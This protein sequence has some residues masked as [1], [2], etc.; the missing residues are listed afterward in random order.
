[1]VVQSPAVRCILEQR[2]AKEQ[3]VKFIESDPKRVP[4]LVQLKLVASTV[5]LFVIFMLNFENESKIHVLYEQGL[6]WLRH[7]FFDL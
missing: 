2:Q 6:I 1:M 4:Q 7:F 3:F 5:T